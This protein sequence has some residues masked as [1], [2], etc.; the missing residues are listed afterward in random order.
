MNINELYTERGRINEEMRRFEA[1][2]RLDATQEDQYSRLENE[3]RGLTQRIRQA[4]GE[5]R[6]RF[7]A[8]LQCAPIKPEPEKRSTAIAPKPGE[9][10]VYSPGTFKIPETPTNA[11]EDR[12]FREYVQRGML[13]LTDEQRARLESRALQMDKDTSGGFAVSP[14]LFVNQFIASLIDQVFIRQYATIIT[15]P[16]AHS[17]GAPALDNDVGDPE[18]GSEL[19][20]GSEDSTMS[21]DKRELTPHP[22]ARYIKVS[23]K[24]IRANPQVDGLIR[25]RLSARF[26]IVEENKFLNGSGANQ[27]LG[28]FTASALGIGTSRDMSTGNTATGILPDNLVNCKYHLR[29]QYRRNARWVFSRDGIKMIR[30]L[31]D[32]EGNYIWKL[33]LS[34]DRPD[35]ILDLPFDES[36]YCPNVFTTG[37]Y[38]GALC[39]W[40]FYWIA[41]ALSMEIQV[42]TELFAATNQNGYVGRKETDAM[43]VLEEAFVRVKLG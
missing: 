10:R 13:G 29:A 2:D 39:N 35:T 7:M 20:F 3:F 6:N 41:D 30:K 23:K 36:E 25:D 31:K 38:V 28:I 21:F 4:E 5:E 15:C 19:N 34:A 18:W 43:P 32:G 8:A 12:D 24:L 26:A 17:L 27:P 16:N 9:I 11:V 42:L 37:Q 1:F 14:E 22:L 33:G 40:Q